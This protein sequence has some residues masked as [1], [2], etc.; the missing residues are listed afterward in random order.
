[1]VVTWDTVRADLATAATAPGLHG[2]G[3]RVF[4]QARTTVPVTLPAHASLLTGRWAA[5]HGARNNGVQTL[6]PDIPTLAESLKARGY[7]TGAFVSASVL[8]RRYGLDR[9][10]DVYDD[11][12]PEGAYERDG[13]DTLAAA[14]AWMDAQ[15]GRDPRFV[16][17]H[18]YDPHRPWPVT[19]DQTDPYIAEISRVDALTTAWTSHLRMERTVLVVT[20]DH[21]E[22][23]GDHGEDSH[24]NF[25]Y[26]ST[27]R[28][29]LHVIWGEKVEAP[30]PA[31]VDDRPVS[32]VDIAPTLASLAGSPF[33]SDGVDLTQTIPDRALAMESMMPALNYGIA[34]LYGVVEDGQVWISAP[35]A[36][37]YALSSDPGQ[38]Q[39]LFTPD[40]APALDE[41]LRQFDWAIDT[42]LSVAAPSD[43]EAAQLAALG[44]VQLEG[45]P[46]RDIDPKDITD[47]FGLGL[48][49]RELLTGPGAAER[50]A[51]LRAMHPTGS[52]RAQL[53]RIRALELGAPAIREREA[54]LLR[55][56]GR[57]KE[58][59]HLEGRPDPSRRQRHQLRDRIAQHIQ[60]NPADAD[61]RYDLAVTLHWLEDD[62]AEAAY[63]QALALRPEDAATRQGLAVLLMQRGDF[64]AAQ[65]AARGLGCLEEKVQIEAGTRTS[66][67][68]SCGPG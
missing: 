55:D 13:V 27:M 45:S 60:A 42:A 63:R 26:D 30:W 51:L 6:D 41:R 50:L 19:D 16:W 4:R 9:G 56:L 58:A 24:G 21:G 64:A 66:A 3:G 7:R 54:A 65:E 67:S 57:R 1:M 40:Q 22:G 43:E 20:S 10:F 59:E 46:D 31:G 35:R 49:H 17:V 8:R 52:L 11:A 44:Y 12:L 25:I 62:D 68:S 39:N 47:V 48:E 61:A 28:V 32:L 5:G 15:P 23:L 38:Q 34:P 53:A 18:L 37:R 2:L 14:A 33:P 29:P 36:E